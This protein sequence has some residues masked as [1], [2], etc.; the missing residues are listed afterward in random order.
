MYRKGNVIPIHEA[1]AP[2]PA[3]ATRCGNL[4]VLAAT[5]ISETMAGGGGMTPY[6]LVVSEEGEVEALGPEH[7]DYSYRILTR[8]YACILTSSTPVT[9][10]AE[11]LRD[12]ALRQRRPM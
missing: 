7:A 11:L 12:A 6:M 2:S 10:V 3:A 4:W 5:V 8:D 1:G 9:R